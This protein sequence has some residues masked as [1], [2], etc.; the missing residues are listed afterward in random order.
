LSAE[1]GVDI[2]LDRQGTL[3]LAFSDED[4]QHLLG[5]YKYQQQAGLDLEYLSQEQVLRP[6]L[7]S[8]LM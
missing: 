2:G 4:H 1:T 8:R 7:I 3:Y 5:K 6:S